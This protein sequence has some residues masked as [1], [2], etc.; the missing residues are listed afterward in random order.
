MGVRINAIYEVDI[1]C[2]DITYELVTNYGATAGAKRK[3]AEAT[4]E[5]DENASDDDTK[6]ENRKN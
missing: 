3:R 4:G 1:S 2:K 5:S 6:Q